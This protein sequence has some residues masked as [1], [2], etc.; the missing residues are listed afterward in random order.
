MGEKQVNPDFESVIAVEKA[1]PHGGK[2]QFG[3]GALKFPDGR[4]EPSIA[5]QIIAPTAPAPDHIVA[6]FALR[7][8]SFAVLLEGMMEV[9]RHVESMALEETRP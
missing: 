1:T 6:Q 5:I 4:Q 2:I 3:V 9:F 7:M 8:E